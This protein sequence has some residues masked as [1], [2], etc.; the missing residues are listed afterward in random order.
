M[1]PIAKFACAAAIMMISAAALG[2]VRALPEP[3]QDDPGYPSLHT[4]IPALSPEAVDVIVG[5]ERY[6]YDNGRW[7]LEDASR[8]TTVKPP[9]GLVISTLPPSFTKRWIDAI[10]YY[11]ADGVYYVPVAGGYAVAKPA[12]Q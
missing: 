3:R 4:A 11:Y 6:W 1:N 12:P 9:A 8:W 5:D 7:Y 2:G 10:P